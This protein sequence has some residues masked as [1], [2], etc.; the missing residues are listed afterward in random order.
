MSRFWGIFRKDRGQLEINQAKAAV[1]LAIG[2]IPR[3]GV[4]V[5]DAVLLDFRKKLFHA[6]VVD[7]VHARTA[8]V[9]DDAQ[10]FG[11][12]LQQAGDKV[13]SA[14][15][16]VTKDPDFVVESFPRVRAVVSLDDP[17]IKGQIHGR[18]QR[19]FNFQHVERKYRAKECA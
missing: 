5:A 10:F 6:L 8:T 4:I 19:V 3:I 13:A 17:A 2:D 15:F 14:F 9:R 7:V 12:G 18:T 11:I 16:E 1:R